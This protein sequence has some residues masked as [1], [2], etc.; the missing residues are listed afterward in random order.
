MKVKSNFGINFLV[1]NDLEEYRVENLK[2]KEPET[3]KWIDDFQLGSTFLDIGA[4]IGQYSLYAGV[5]RSCKV[6]SFEPYYKNYIK[7]IENIKANSCESS[8]SPILCALS[9]NQ[10]LSNFYIKDDRSSS[11]GH[12]IGNNKDE[13]G[14]IFDPIS[15][16]PVM[17]F[18]L[19]FFLKTFSIESPNYIKIDVDGNESEIIKGMRG[20][21]K[22]SNLKSILIEINTQVENSSNILNYIMNYGFSTENIY[23]NMLQH[24]RI[25]RAK[26]SNNIAENIIFTKNKN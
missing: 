9:S 22:N 4:N 16:Y 11:S 23:N 17:T 19:D 12:Q 3:I 5:K 2:E 13:L 15:I 20:V 26:N 21:L 8:I 25:R 18:S 24:S 10:Q 6:Y 1:E 14:N 7:L